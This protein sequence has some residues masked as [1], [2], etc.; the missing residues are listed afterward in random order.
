MTSL[1]CKHCGNIHP[2][3]S[4]EE[5]WEHQ[6]YQSGTMVVT[7]V[8]NCSAPW[9]YVYGPANQNEALYVRDRMQCC[10]QLR[11]FLMGGE[12]PT[13]LDD[14]RR[15]SEE[16]AEDLDGTQVT[17]CGPMYD[18]NPPRLQ[19]MPDQSTE[20]KNARARLMDRLFLKKEKDKSD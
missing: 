13:W 16:H 3:C 4:N 17:A 7:D 20:A 10:K 15:V 2:K 6:C 5:K 11:E 8:N 9:L 19:W 1:N 14:L 12:R 18:A